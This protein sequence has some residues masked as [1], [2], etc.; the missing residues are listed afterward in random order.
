MM[1]QQKRLQNTRPVCGHRLGKLQQ[2]V[3]STQKAAACVGETG[4]QANV[5]KLTADIQCAEELAQD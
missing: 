5:A 3:A 2:V 4:I 1:N